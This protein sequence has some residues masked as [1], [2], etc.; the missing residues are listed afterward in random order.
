MYV[1]NYPPPQGGFW[2]F[3]HI[4][5]DAAAQKIYIFY[6]DYYTFRYENT[7]TGTGIANIPMGSNG[8]LIFGC[9]PN[10]IN[11][12]C[13]SGQTSRPIFAPYSRKTTPYDTL[14]FLFKGRL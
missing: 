11:M 5:L 7:V 12:Q 6:T 8:K 10:S 1:K 13:A 14:G 3:I 2:A 9:I 4:E